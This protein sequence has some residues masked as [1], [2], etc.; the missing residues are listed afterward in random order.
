MAKTPAHPLD[1]PKYLR[2][3]QDKRRAAWEKNP[4]RP[5]PAFVPEPRAVDP[6]VQRFMDEE[7]QRQRL[8]T[9]AR[10]NKMK[11]T[12]RNKAEKV[13]TRNL[14]WDSRHNRW[15][16]LDTGRTAK[17]PVIPVIER[18][19]VKPV[20]T[21]KDRVKAAMRNGR[22]ELDPALI[23]KFAKANDAWDDKYARLTLSLQCMNVM[24]RVLSRKAKN[25]SHKIV[26]TGG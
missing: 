6:E 20:S 2:V 24:N 25:P 11:E 17:F 5:A 1:T 13:D 21:D 3:P 12:Q 16:S 7:R 23:K 22:G 19:K 10:I 4:P 14:R 8:K 18:P 15:V 26:Y 9:M